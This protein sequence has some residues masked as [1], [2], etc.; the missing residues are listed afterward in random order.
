[1]AQGNRS[2]PHTPDDVHGHYTARKAL[3][4]PR[5]TRGSWPATA[6]LGGSDATLV[7]QLSSCWAK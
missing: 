5:P 4:C 6:L 1:M 7:A 2:L 3:P